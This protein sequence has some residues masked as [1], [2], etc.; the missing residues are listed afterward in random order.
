MGPGVTRPNPFL[1]HASGSFSATSSGSRILFSDDGKYAA[2]PGDPTHEVAGRPAT[3]LMVWDVATG[4]TVVNEQSRISLGPDFLQRNVEFATIGA[5]P[6]VVASVKMPMVVIPGRP[7]EPGA[8]SSGWD[9]TTGEKRTDHRLEQELRAARGSRVIKAYR[10][11]TIEDPITGI[12]LL[13]LPLGAT[14]TGLPRLNVDRSRL[15]V[16]TDRGIVVFDVGPLPEFSLPEDKPAPSV[17][18]TDKPVS[19]DLKWAHGDHATVTD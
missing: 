17:G 5:H 4:R 9:L 1:A 8:L 2:W 10:V 11:L 12:E 3:T 18:S 6:W 13:Q 14:A 7:Y 15:A 16:A 19:G